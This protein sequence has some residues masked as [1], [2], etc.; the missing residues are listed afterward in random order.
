MDLSRPTFDSNTNISIDSS[1]RGVKTWE[2]LKEV[3]PQYNGLGRALAYGLS[4][5]A[6]DVSFEAKRDFANNLKTVV[7]FN[8]PQ[9][10]T[11]RNSLE[12]M[13]KNLVKLRE[14]V[15][16]NTTQEQGK[17]IREIFSAITKA[18]TKSRD[19]EIA[20]AKAKAIEVK[21]AA[22]KAKHEAAVKSFSEDV[23]AGLKNVDQLSPEKFY[24]DFGRT[25]WFGLFGGFNSRIRIIENNGR[26]EIFTTPKLGLLQR[27]RG[28]RKELLV[29]FEEKLA[30]V[31]KLRQMIHR[32]ELFIK[33][34]RF[35]VE[36]MA[37]YLQAQLPRMCRNLTPSQAAQISREVKP[38]IADLISYGNAIV[39]AR[40]KDL[41]R[42]CGRGLAWAG[43][44]LVLRPAVWTGKNCVLQPTFWAGKKV[45]KGAATGVSYGASKAGA[46]IV[47]GA[48]GIKSGLNWL[49]QTATARFS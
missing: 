5:F 9:F 31:K 27:F 13:G 2:I 40:S 48:S 4:W 41:S 15:A 24:N 32:D 25:A 37:A 1:G 36:G 7:E 34:K 33:E 14:K 43:K 21:A 6:S 49:K 26:F 45:V 3:K 8:E 47:Y 35:P 16:K 46:G 38:T 39:E 10:A 20:K 19:A 42:R 11:W 22:D 28:N 23:P 29:S 30:A 18:S 12:V 17:E 44:N